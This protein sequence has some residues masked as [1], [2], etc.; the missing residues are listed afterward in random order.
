MRR[1]SCCRSCRS[2]KRKGKEAASF[3]HKRNFFPFRFLGFFPFSLDHFN[4]FPWFLRM[5]HILLTTPKF[6]HPS[7]L[8]QESAADQVQEANEKTARSGDGGKGIFFSRASSIPLFTPHTIHFTKLPLR[9]LSTQSTGLPSQMLFCFGQAREEKKKKRNGWEKEK[10][11][12]KMKEKNSQWIKNKLV[13]WRMSWGNG[14]LVR[15]DMW[16]RWAGGWDGV[17][18]R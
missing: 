4:P 10:K 18:S 7:L 6:N 1:F 3:F 17:S 15:K 12:E 2:C 14:T 13:I 5:W 9:D 8:F 11:N 16:A